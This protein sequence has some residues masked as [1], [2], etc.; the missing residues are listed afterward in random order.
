[1]Y[2]GG[3][4]KEKKEK[5]E[6]LKSIS[7]DVLFT[8][9]PFVS[10]VDSVIANRQQRFVR[11]DCDR[12]SI[13]RRKKERENGEKGARGERFDVLIRCEIGRLTV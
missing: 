3:E 9:Q 1:M 11:I 10:S 13:C 4:K 12:A 8:F 7:N 6:I 2:S 5:R